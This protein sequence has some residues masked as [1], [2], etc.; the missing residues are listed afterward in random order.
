M[1]ALAGNYIQRKN[2]KK[3]AYVIRCDQL[4]ET[5]IMQYNGNKYTWTLFKDY[6]ANKPVGGWDYDDTSKKLNE[7]D[8]RRFENA[9]YIAGPIYCK[10]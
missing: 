3:E 1:R 2:G 4:E 8:K 5:D 7:E 6:W 9:W 10:K